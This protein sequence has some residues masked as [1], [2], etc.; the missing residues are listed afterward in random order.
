MKT[1]CKPHRICIRKRKQFCPLRV[2]S[3]HDDI[4]AAGFL[5]NEAWPIRNQLVPHVAAR[6]RYAKPADLD[7]QA[8]R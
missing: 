4:P 5:T 1:A 7:Q 8:A 3:N 2:Q 6:L